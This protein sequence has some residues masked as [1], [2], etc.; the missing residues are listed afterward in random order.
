MGKV[1]GAEK[2]KGPLWKRVLERGKGAPSPVV[3]QKSGKV[4]DWGFFSYLEMQFAISFKLFILYFYFSVYNS[5]A[6]V[7]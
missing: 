7:P 6:L 4:E 2:D 1:L 3:T 5:N